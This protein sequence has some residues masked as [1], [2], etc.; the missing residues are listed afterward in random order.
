VS[1]IQ[2]NGDGSV[3]Y[4]SSKSNNLNDNETIEFLFKSN[5]D[6]MVMLDSMGS[7]F[8]IHLQG[9]GLTIRNK[10]DTFSTTLIERGID[11]NDGHLHKFKLEKQ[12]YFRKLTFFENFSTANY[13]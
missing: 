11:F 6:R 5:G 8:L 13:F 4:Q 12:F 10:D 1:N 9:P 2:L 7:D 3:K